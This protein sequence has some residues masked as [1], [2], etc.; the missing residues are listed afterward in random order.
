MATQGKIVTLFED[1]DKT[2]GVFPRTKVSAISNN[3]GVGLDALLIDAICVGED[4]EKTQSLPIDADTL[5]GYTA[6]ELMANGGG[7]GGSGVFFGNET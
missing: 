3:D 2:Q 6:A 4:L 7:S 5:N 1:K